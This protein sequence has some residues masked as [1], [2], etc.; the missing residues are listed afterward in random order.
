MLPLVNDTGKCKS[1]VNRNEVKA[2]PSAAKCICRRG[3]PTRA[4]RVRT[5]GILGDAVI[6]KRTT[7]VSE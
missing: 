4:A 6:D 2:F 1:T 3:G 5:L 7:C